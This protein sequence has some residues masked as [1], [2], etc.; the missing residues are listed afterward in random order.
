MTINPL[1][2]LPPKKDKFGRFINT[3]F[4]YWINFERA[5]N[6]DSVSEEA[7]TMIAL[8]AVYDK[9]DVAHLS[10]YIEGALWF[11]NCGR[12]PTDNDKKNRPSERI[13]DYDIDAHRIIVSFQQQYGLRIMH[14]AMHWWEFTTF[15]NGLN[16]Q[17]IMGAVMNARAAKFTPGMSKSEREHLMKMKREFS[18]QRV[19][20]TPMTE[21]EFI[22]NA[23]E[24]AE[25]LRKQR[26][27][28]N[29]Q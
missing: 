26:L 16:D 18:L 2:N 28:N 15:L 29:V 5:L 6:D 3:D 11:Y 7:R 21:D 19:D 14:L 20:E 4:R 22:K 1:V 12:E 9:V 17:T 13:I 25:E 24:R 10:E 23:E 8:N 27:K